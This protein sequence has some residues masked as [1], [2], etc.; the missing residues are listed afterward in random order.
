MTDINMNKNDN[1]KEAINH[2]NKFK[3]PPRAENK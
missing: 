3:N 2:A 1:K